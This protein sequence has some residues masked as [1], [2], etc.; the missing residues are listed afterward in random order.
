MTIGSRPQAFQQ[1]I[2]GVPMLFLSPPKGGSEAN[3]KKFQ[4]NK[5]WYRVSLCEN[6]QQHNRSV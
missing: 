5:V 6:F 4:S 1:V 2:D 3:F